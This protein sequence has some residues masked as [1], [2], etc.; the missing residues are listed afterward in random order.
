MLRLEA[1]GASVQKRLQPT[2]A[3]REDAI[4]IERSADDEL[5]DALF[6]GEFCAVLAPRQ[7]GKSSLRVRIAR[8]LVEAGIHCAQID[9]TALGKAAD[10]DPI[11]SWYFS[12]ATRIADELN[13]QDPKPFFLQR[14]DLLPADRLL[15]YLAREVLPACVGPVVI[16]LDEIDYLRALPID[17]DEFFV[18]LRALYNERAQQSELKRLSFCLLGV[19]APRDLVKN[20]DIT[21]FNIGQLVRLLDFDRQELSA[22][23]PVL[24]PLCDDED[25]ILDEMYSWTAGHPYMTQA[26]CQ[27][28]LKQRGA[29]AQGS[30]AERVE[31]AVLGRFLHTGR[32]SDDNLSYAE[33]RLDQSP[34]K[35]ALLALYRRLLIK[36]EL[37]LDGGDPE[38]Q[39]L[40]LCGLAAPSA[41]EG[42]RH[43]RV[44][45]RI[46]AQVFHAAWIHEKEAQRQ[47]GVAYR[48]WIESSRAEAELL[49]G[50][51]LQEAQEWTRE[52]PREATA[53][54]SEFLLACLDGARREADQAR[55][56][57]L[58]SLEQERRARAEAATRTQRRIII[59]LVVFTLLLIG[60]LGGMYY[61]YHRA[62][63]ARQIAS[64]MALAEQKLRKEIEQTSD[65]KQKE[66][67]RAERLS[68]E[69]EVAKK[70]F[71]DAKQKL[72]QKQEQVAEA[73]QRLDELKTDVR[74]T[75][76]DL[77]QN[78][79]T[80]N[81]L[82]AAQI[83]SSL[84]HRLQALVIGMHAVLGD[85]QSE[86]IHPR[87]WEGLTAASRSLVGFRQIATNMPRG[88][89]A[90]MSGDAHLL[91][92]G[93]EKGE[94]Y[95][96]DA[97]INDR[98]WF[99]QICS[100]KAVLH[101]S[102]SQNGKY[103]AA[104][105]LGRSASILDAQT[106]KFLQEVA[107]GKKYYFADFLGDSLSLKIS[108]FP[109]KIEAMHTIGPKD[110]PIP[111]GMMRSNNNRNFPYVIQR[112]GQALAM[113]SQGVSVMVSGNLN[114]LAIS[115]DNSL[116]ASDTSH[117]LSV[118][119]TKKGA[120][121]QFLTADHD[122][123]SLQFSDDKRYL[124]SVTLW[125]GRGIK[126]W[127]LMQ[128]IGHSWSIG[129]SYTFDSEGDFSIESN[130]LVV[131]K[132]SEVELRRIS[133]MKLIQ[134]VKLPTENS[135][136]FKIRL[137]SS[138]RTLLIASEYASKTPRILQLINVSNGRL[139]HEKQFPNESSYAVSG[140][141]ERY[142]LNGKESAMQV[143]E[144]H[145]GRLL[146]SWWLPVGGVRVEHVSDYTGQRLV[147][148]AGTQ[149][150]LLAAANG[151]LL[152]ILQLPDGTY[153]R[154]NSAEISRQGQYLIVPSARDLWV[155]DLRSGKRQHLEGHLASINR[156]AI[157]PDERYLVSGSDDK[158]VRLWDL[159]T[160]ESRLTIPLD[161]TPELVSFLGGGKQILA[162]QQN[163]I[164]R[165]FPTEHKDWF[166]FACAIL[167]SIPKIN[168]VS[169]ED[170]KKALS[171]CP[172]Q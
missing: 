167:R 71:T 122:N 39:E 94:V 59:G 36:G 34:Q 22:F 117:G 93:T 66:W 154:L 57:S 104:S 64:D 170:R 77:E 155:W 3:L 33:K 110:E 119:E 140:N 168:A 160:G 124:M 100:D 32:S 63:L 27:E 29:Q 43:L 79:Q 109:D 78:K 138:G 151:D 127:D 123:H 98:L 25:T 157:S 118:V 76:I 126:L 146:Y 35:A 48:R 135:Y 133:D 102:F 40:Q 108:E 97:R 131:E 26:L 101:L 152:R 47:L 15:Q 21:P 161:D 148:Q 128:T 107:T 4:Y 46:F 89:T 159:A 16:F 24:A 44:R 75:T 6:A 1:S 73:E 7:I 80:V 96:F 69:A 70:Q 83:A 9:L 129:A 164:A 41:T 144:T 51:A 145:T 19:A 85:V 50:V 112:P 65:A 115:K 68:K 136:M 116:L 2:G 171:A 111:I 150:F 87:R 147:V 8:R 106:G 163:G 88:I 86:Q 74:K 103:L 30:P 45:N 49:R 120:T 149:M 114:N 172:S 125:G 156:F 23:A 28:L 31:R 72:E 5:Y 55:L 60:L 37:P 67:E 53:E 137:L 141:G 20:P 121:L 92:L 12:L 142:T 14:S 143:F 134:K 54:E 18:A 99:S 153:L 132:Y 62:E 10:R 95:S 81:S 11:S 17:R 90:A 162:I 61:Q 166:L 58:A 56:A 105:C 139:I 158:T 91:S 42:L 84:E 113:L 169:D 52:H 13:L 130:L 38:Q 165:T 82:G